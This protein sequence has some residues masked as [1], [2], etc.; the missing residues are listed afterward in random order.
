VDASIPVPGRFNVEN[1]LAALLTATL[2][3]GRSPEEFVPALSSLAAA[4][5]RMRVVQTEPYAVIVDYAHTPGAFEQA[6]PFFR[7]QTPGRLIVVFG[8][9]GERDREKRP[10]LGQIA[11]R[12]AHLIILADEDPRMEDALQVLEEVAAGCPARVRGD[13][14]R[15]IRDRREAIRTAFRLAQPGDTVLLLGKGHETSIIGAT[16]P[17]PW[18]EETVAR[19][20]LLDI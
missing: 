2:A 15:I 12:Y 6:L 8:A 17:E 18:D 9:A 20:E 10:L 11:D 19:E 3:T 1:A 4:K 14:L 13:D 16:G 5:G 7:T